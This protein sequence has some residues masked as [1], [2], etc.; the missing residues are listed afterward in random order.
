MGNDCSSTDCANF[1]AG[2]ILDKTLDKRYF[3]IHTY[4]YI[5]PRETLIYVCRISSL[6]N[7]AFIERVFR[8][9]L[10]KRVEF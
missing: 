6:D 4:I 3:K 1:A 9:Y 10:A 7:F 2:E 5:Y 8:S